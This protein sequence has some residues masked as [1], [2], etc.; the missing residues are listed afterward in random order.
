MKLSISKLVSSTLLVTVIS[1]QAQ[2]MDHAVGIAPVKSGLL[3]SLGKSELKSFD[4]AESLT[5]LGYT[6]VTGG[7]EDAEIGFSLGYRQAFGERWSADMQ[8]IRQNV[9]SNPIGVT[10]N[11]GSEAAAAQRISENLPKLAQ[12][13]SLVGLYHA[14][15][16]AR[17]TSHFGGGV[18]IWRGERE[19]KIGTATATDEERGTDAMLQLGLGYRFTPKVTV[20]G[21]IQRFF[22]PD[23]AVNRMSI[24]M[25]YSF[26]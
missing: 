3:F 15:L 4:V 9:R 25:V 7:E 11:S 21:S 26:N 14:P 8:Y 2:S 6:G 20:E 10:V 12:G 23:E 18:F 17:L 24:G 1:S 22:M 19:T 16:S 5:A 13:L